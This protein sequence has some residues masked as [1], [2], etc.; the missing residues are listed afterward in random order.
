MDT[1][2]VEY[3]NAQARNYDDNI[4]S[5]IDED[6]TGIILQIIERCAGLAGETGALEADGPF[7]RCVDLG[8]G[9]GKYLPAL[10]SRFRTVAGYDLSPKLVGLARKEVERRGLQNVTVN[11]RDLLDVWFRNGNMP[12]EEMESYG[13]AV[14]ANVLIAPI[15]DSERGLMLRNASRCLCPGGHLMV[16]VPSL[17]SAMYVNMRCEEVSC[18]GP[19]AARTAKVVGDDVLRKPSKAEGADL[20]RGILKRSGVRTKHFL[21][22]EFQL[23]AARTGFVVETVEKVCYS[24]CAELGLD[25]QS[26]VPAGLREPPLPWDWLFLLRRDEGCSG[27]G[28]GASAG[29]APAVLVATGDKDTSG[30]R[31]A[32]AGGGD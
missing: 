23:L 6:T 21:E 32:K 11:T 9:A 3:W 10:S 29:A 19:Y 7:S 13:F 27:A 15:T 24:W 25:S 20:L 26:Q 31:A 18:D 4:F 5:T 28:A 8:C 17:E 2:P 22:V 14:L 16:I 30:A 1:H 12:S